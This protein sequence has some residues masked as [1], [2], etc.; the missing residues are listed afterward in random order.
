ML[1]PREELPIEDFLDAGS[2]EHSYPAELASN[3][4]EGDRLHR[5]SIVELSW[6]NTDLIYA[7]RHWDLVDI[8]TGEPFRIESDKHIHLNPVENIIR[9]HIDGL[10]AELNEQFDVMLIPVEHQD[11]ESAEVYTDVLRYV[12]H[13]NELSFL[14]R[15]L[16]SNTANYGIGFWGSDWD[17]NWKGGRGRNRW[18]GEVR[19]E[20]PDVRNIIPDRRCENSLDDG[21]RLHKQVRA[22]V[23]SAR[24][25]FPKKAHL[26]HDN[27]TANALDS[28]S[29][30]S[31]PP[32]QSGYERDSGQV[33]LVTTWYKGRPLITDNGERINE[34]GMN[35]LY[36]I[37]QE[38]PLYLGHDNNVM[39]TSQT[40]PSFP[41]RALVFDKRP[42]SIYGYSEIDYLLYPQLMRNVSIEQ[43]QEAHISSGIGQL[44]LEKGVADPEEM[45]QI[46]HLS[47]VPNAMLVVND[48]RKK[49]RVRADAPPA[50]LTQEIERASRTMELM[51][52]RY[53]V[54]RGQAPRN[55]EAYSALQLLV[56][57][58]KIRMQSKLQYIKLLRIWLAKRNLD[59]I[60]QHYTAIRTYMVSSEPQK[61][62][63]D[64]KL[65][66]PNKHK[67]VAWLSRPEMPIQPLSDV[68]EAMEGGT[69][70]EIAQRIAT[71]RKL[72]PEKDLEIYSPEFNA[73]II[74]TSEKPEDRLHNMG[75]AG[76]LL[77]NGH[78]TL[79]DFLRT[80][81]QGRL[82]SSEEIQ[83]RL[84]EQQQAQQAAQ[85]MAQQQPAIPPGIPGAEAAGPPMAAGADMLGGLP[86]VPPEG[87]LPPESLPMGGVSV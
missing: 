82:P 26:I 28:R 14:Q 76:E 13:K 65:Y 63:M 30:I 49:E 64:Q 71:S 31:I 47:V 53:D 58:A 59:L 74:I 48:L 41:Y 34:N 83:K 38:T 50:T 81:E 78:I 7:N 24:R 73:E 72:D 19:I 37:D 8:H 84:D 66:E 85:Q 25:M 86:T 40:T 87:A 9:P 69:D 44:W 5:Q 32:H 10:I 75:L 27:F 61:K 6:Q 52:G 56:N 79:V 80:I 29:P 70:E 12:E 21:E 67:R 42:Q 46:E 17:P 57:Q 68:P 18:S 51:V 2:D 39:P 11:K 35:V 22:T 23:E 54:T 45:N 62:F 3:W 15:N 77:K 55:I 33:L 20:V 16:I 4:L 36:W 1:H 43:I 60:Q